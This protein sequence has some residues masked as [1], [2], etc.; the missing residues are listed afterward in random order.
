MTVHV[1]QSDFY[2]SQYGVT[3]I[4]SGA[5][6]PDD[7]YGHWTYFEAVEMEEDTPPFLLGDPKEMIH[8]IQDNGYWVSE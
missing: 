4:A 8:S 1:F 7:V 2:L 3:P 5:N 6:L